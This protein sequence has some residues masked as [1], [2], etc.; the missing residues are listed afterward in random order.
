MK[1]FSSVAERGHCAPREGVFHPWKLSAGST[2]V[3]SGA[4]G[5]SVNCCVQALPPGIRRRAQHAR[6]SSVITETKPGGLN[7]P[8]R[9]DFQ[10][11]SDNN[12]E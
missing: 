10:I 6:H 8:A 5:S 9:F 11:C 3:S 12:W 7:R 4:S 1:H 2:H